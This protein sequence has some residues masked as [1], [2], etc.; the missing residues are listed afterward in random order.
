MAEKCGLTAE[1]GQRKPPGSR[2]N[3]L[4]GGKELYECTIQC[5]VKFILYAFLFS[6]VL[7]CFFL[8]KHKKLKQA[9][10]NLSLLLFLTGR[11]R[12]RRAVNVGNDPN[13]PHEAHRHPADAHFSHCHL[14]SRVS[15]TDIKHAGIFS[16]KPDLFK[17][18]T[19]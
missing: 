1:R 6:C 8:G 17:R 16:R 9:E 5:E 18:H 14:F 7:F 19:V 12:R 13:L 11:R 15:D 4:P 3:N 2:S 10:K